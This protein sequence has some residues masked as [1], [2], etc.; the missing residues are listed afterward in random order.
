MSLDD[1]VFKTILDQFLN[2]NNLNAE[3]L[4][5]HHKNTCTTPCNDCPERDKRIY[6]NGEHIRLPVHPHCDCY[7]TNVETKPLGSISQK[8]PSPDVWLKLYGKLPDYYITKEEA[9]EKYGWDSSKNTLAGKAPGKM[10]GGDIY[11]NIPVILPVKEGR[12]WKECDI[13][14]I[15]GKRDKARLYYSNDGLIF[16]SPD[17]L[18]GNVTVYQ[19][20]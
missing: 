1:S 6:K 19:V 14:Y 18:D 9:M 5:Y 8:Q 20:K 12:I 16:Y 10:I 11:N 17:H 3:Y 15:S 4:Q 7:Y 2:Q 13:D